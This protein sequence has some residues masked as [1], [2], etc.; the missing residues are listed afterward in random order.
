[1]FYLNLVDYPMLFLLLYHEM[2][3][4][5]QVYD[6]EDLQL[7]DAERKKKNKKEPLGRDRSIVIARGD[8]AI[9]S[10]ENIQTIYEKLKLRESMQNYKDWSIIGD[11]KAHNSTCGMCILI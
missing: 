1:M 11:L 3:P 2:I 10:P 4:I 6:L 8:Y 9:E 7:T 5:I